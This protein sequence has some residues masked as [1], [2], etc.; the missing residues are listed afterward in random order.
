MVYPFGD[1]IHYISNSEKML[2]MQIDELQKHLSAHEHKEIN[3]E[4]AEPTIEDRFIQLMQQNA[5]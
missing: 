1:K 3:I 4:S 5:A 2:Q